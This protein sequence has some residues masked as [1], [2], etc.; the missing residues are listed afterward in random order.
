M[1]KS[2]SMSRLSSLTAE[3]YNSIMC[4]NSPV[5]DTILYLVCG[6]FPISFPTKV[7]EVPLLEFVLYPKIYFLLKNEKELQD[8]KR[9]DG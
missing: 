2:S 7:L 1:E 6:L 8:L 5:L 4:S 3:T 9:K